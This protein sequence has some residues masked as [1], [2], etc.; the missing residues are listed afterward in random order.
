MLL[1]LP[2]GETFRPDPLLTL[3][4]FIGYLKDVTIRIVGGPPSP[5]P[6]AA[7]VLPKPADSGGGF[8]PIGLFPTT[9]RIWF[10]ARQDL[11]RRWERSHQRA[12]LYAGPSMG[13]QV[14]AW[15]STYAA[16]TA[17]TAL[18]NS[19]CA[20][21]NIWPPVLRSD[22]AANFPGE[23]VK[24]ERTVGNQAHHGVEVAPASNRW[25]GN[26]FSC[27]RPGAWDELVAYC[28]ANP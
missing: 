18:V 22:A 27:I 25:Y 17:A 5:E 12:C 10:K 19:V 15:K 8:R 20:L 24:Y 13:A 14:A 7:P 28:M 9:I 6:T 11:T 21:S 1:F 26:R 4:D 23:A 3:A 2:N 16:E